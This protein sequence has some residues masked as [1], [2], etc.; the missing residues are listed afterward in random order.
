MA[1]ILPAQLTGNTL[2]QA[3]RLELL[4]TTTSFASRN[5]NAHPWMK[6]PHLMTILAAYW[7]RPLSHLPQSVE[8]LIEVEPGTRLL[9]KCHWHSTP[10]EHSTIVLLHGLEGSSD[11]HYMLGTADKAFAAGFNVLR[12]NQRNCGGTEHL[13][14]TLYHAGLSEDYRVVLNELIIKDRLPE[15]IFIGYSIGGNLVLKMA[16]ELGTE[17][18]EE[19][20]GICAVS[21]CLD[22]GLSSRGSGAFRNRLYESHFLQSLRTRMRRKAKLFPERYATA[23][24]ARVKTLR[25]WDDVIT[26]PASGYRSAAEYYSQAS[27]LRVI[28]QISVPTLILTAQDDPLVPMASFD[29]PGIAGNPFI[30]LVAPEHGGHCAFISCNDGDERFWAESRAIE[31]CTRM[32]RM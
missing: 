13:T 31:F 27:A 18:P 5:F 30:T 12:M 24:H 19:L 7:P 2:K 1:E 6:N 14:P 25:E 8:R 20:R 16:G 26:A 28:R 17:S 22:L 10:R 3:R 15:V 21:P 4:T 29:N 32:S 23:L 11:S 9:V